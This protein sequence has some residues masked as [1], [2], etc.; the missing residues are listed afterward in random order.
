M[1]IEDKY[2]RYDAIFYLLILNPL[3]Y[4]SGLTTNLY[5]TRW[6]VTI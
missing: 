6:T 4:S 1:R 3:G 5:P 2:M